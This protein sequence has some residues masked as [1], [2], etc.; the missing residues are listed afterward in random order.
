M[1]VA[2]RVPRAVH[3][4]GASCHTDGTAGENLAP[5]R[6]AAHLLWKGGH[7]TMTLDL[8]PVQSDLI[9]VLT[10]LAID[11][12]P[13]CPSLSHIQKRHTVCESQD[14]SHVLGPSAGLVDR[15]HPIPGDA[16][17]NSV[18]SPLC[19][20]KENEGKR[21]MSGRKNPSAPFL[22]NFFFFT[23]IRTNTDCQCQTIFLL[24]DPII[25]V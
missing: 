25:I 8:P 14:W 5:R 10:P 18:S 21:S 20:V 13:L 22:L 23:R 3:V 12:V 11:A 7:N 2:R 1:H 16:C 24:V 15:A 9:C 19:N 4:I 6:A 17:R